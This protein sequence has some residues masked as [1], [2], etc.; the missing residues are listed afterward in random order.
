MALVNVVEGAGGKIS[1]KFGKPITLQS[2]GSLI[3]SS[4]DTLHNEIINL[5]NQ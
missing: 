3:A 5:I 4:S 2:D 1:D